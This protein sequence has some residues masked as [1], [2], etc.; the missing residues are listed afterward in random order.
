MIDDVPLAVGVLADGLADLGDR[1]GGLGD[2]L[3][4]AEGVEYTG[5]APS[6]PPQPTSPTRAAACTG[7]TDVPNTGATSAAETMAAAAFLL[8]CMGI[9]SPSSDVGSVCARTLSG[10]YHQNLDARLTAIHVNEKQ[11]NHQA[12]SCKVMTRSSSGEAAVMGGCFPRERPA[13]PHFT[14][15]VDPALTGRDDL[16]Q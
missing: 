14:Y 8:N 1:L 4:D 16:T 5:K 7:I 3:G 6:D 2:V 11:A 9:P 13:V 15:A 12:A 10:A